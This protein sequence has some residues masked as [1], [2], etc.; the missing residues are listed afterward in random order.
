MFDEM[1]KRGELDFWGSLKG[2]TFS[3]HL[4]SYFTVYRAQI[5]NSP[6]FYE[7]LNTLPPKLERLT[8]I[9]EY[10]IKI[11]PYLE[12]LGYKWDAYID[13]EELEYLTYLAKDWY[14]LSLVSKHKSQFFKRRVFNDEEYSKEDIFEL[15][16]YLKHNHPKTYSDVISANH[17]LLQNLKNKDN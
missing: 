4:C 2:Q 5:F 9:F 11:T 8:A 3:N 12:A 17:R 15:L 1:D 16:D 10:E 14:P 7:I 13:Y 6:Y